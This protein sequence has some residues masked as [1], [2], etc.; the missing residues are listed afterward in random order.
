[1]T[2]LNGI[3][4]RC[5]LSS[6]CHSFATSLSGGLSGSTLPFR[7]LKTHFFD[8]V[9]TLLLPILSYFRLRV[10]SRGDASDGDWWQQ[11][12]S[13]DATVCYDGEEDTPQ[14]SLGSCV[15]G[16][17]LISY[18][19]ESDVHPFGRNRFLDSTSGGANVFQPVL[20][21]V[22]AKDSWDFCTTPCSNSST[23]RSMT[24]SNSAG[25]PPSRS[26]LVSRITPGS[27]HEEDCH[28]ARQGHR[29][30]ANRFGNGLGVGSIYRIGLESSNT[31]EK[32]S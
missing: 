19:I 11:V 9:A 4:G 1:M 15:T 10:P 12:D 7:K 5:R 13:A 20:A 16:L 18:A 27:R 21:A 17:W 28:A 2:A 14:H 23:A 24:C 25:H 26:S 32:L 29:L 8:F 22:I 6:S 3:R 31:P 30:E